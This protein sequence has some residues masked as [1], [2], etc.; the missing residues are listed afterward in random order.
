MPREEGPNE[1]QCYGLIGGDDRTDHRSAPEAAAVGKAHE[2][3]ITLMDKTFRVASEGLQN[4]RPITAQRR[5]VKRRNRGAIGLRRGTQ[6]RK[7]AAS[8]NTTGRAMP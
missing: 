4:A 8:G 3:P 7:A 5:A 2:A 1:S 6:P